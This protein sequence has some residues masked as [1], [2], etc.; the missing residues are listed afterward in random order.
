MVAAIEKKA[1][2]GRSAKEGRRVQAAG[3]GARWSKV[4][5]RRKCP[6]CHG[7]R[8]LVCLVG[9]GKSYFIW[10]EPHLEYAC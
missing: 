4:Q 9:E 8:A 1:S 6:L 10:W 5:G 2:L 7:P 3:L